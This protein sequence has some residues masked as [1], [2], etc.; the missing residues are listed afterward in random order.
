MS[1]N[2]QLTILIK[3]FF[4]NSSNKAPS[5]NLKFVKYEFYTIILTLKEFLKKKIY[6]NKLISGDR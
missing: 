4:S 3:T 2:L 5:C 1:I 6:P